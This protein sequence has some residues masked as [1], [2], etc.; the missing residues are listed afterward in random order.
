MMGVELNAVARGGRASFTASPIYHPSVE[1]QF[2]NLPHIPEAWLFDAVGRMTDLERDRMLRCKII[3]YCWTP[4]HILHCAVDES[5]VTDARRL[6]LELGGRVEKS[7]YHKLIQR[8]FAAELERRA[9]HSL[10][11]LKPWASARTRLSNSQIVAATVILLALIDIALFRGAALV[12]EG[13]QLLAGLF[14]LI[15]IGLRFLCLMPL[16]RAPGVVAPIRDDSELPVYTVLVPLFRETAVLN[17]LVHFL[18]LLDYPPEK[19][20]IKIILEQNDRPMHAAVQSL[21]LPPWFNIIVVPAGH[22]QT[23]PRALNFAMQFARGALVTVYDGEDI[24]HSSQ[25]RLAAAQFLQSEN[26][27]ACLQASLDFYNPAENWLTRHFTSEYAALFRVVLPALAAYGLPLPLGGTSNHFRASALRVVGHWDAHNVTEDADLGIRLA[28]HG[29]RCGI[30]HSTTL[31]EANTELG[32]W[33]KQRRR[34]LKGYLQTWL[35]HTRHPLRVVHETGVAGFLVVQAITVGVFASALLHPLLLATAIWN[36]LPEQ[37]AAKTASLTGS[38]ISGASLVILIAG[39]VSAIAT[40]RAGLK[41]IGVVRWSGVLATIPVYWLLISAAAWMALW[42]FV[43]A[44]FHWHKTRHGLSRV[45]AV[46]G[47]GK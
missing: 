2:E 36:F 12:L 1:L 10:S 4:D 29:F 39:Y 27:V 19:L 45:R 25:L 26:E 46:T 22:P 44:P 32:N 28:R 34:W 15:V 14:F 11:R 13:I 5:A 7:T 24:P 16:P 30:L 43:V 47:R 20:D 33:T 41:K 38:M 21:N 23:K 6:G 9:V 18:S 42:D 3:P 37:L 35:V 31:E 17:R 40:S 8:K